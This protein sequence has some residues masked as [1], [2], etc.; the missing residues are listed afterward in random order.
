[1]I[2]RY[3]RR[4]VVEQEVLG[5]LALVLG[6]RRETLDAFGIDDGEIEACLGAVIEEDGV[7]N[8]ARA[9]WQPERDVRMPRTVRT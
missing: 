7:N 3:L 9:R 6:N 5:Q 4:N 1:M 8:L 2:V